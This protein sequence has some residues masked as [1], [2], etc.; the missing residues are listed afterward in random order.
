[1]AERTIGVIV[2]G[3]DVDGYEV[4]VFCPHTPDGDAMLKVLEK[5]TKFVCMRPNYAVSREAVRAELAKEAA[6]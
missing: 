1:M 5:R 6:R 2:T 3:W 4:R